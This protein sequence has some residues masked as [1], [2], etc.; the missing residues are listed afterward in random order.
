[1]FMQWLRDYLVF[2]RTEI[3]GVMVV[4]EQVLAGVRASD[5]AYGGEPDRAQSIAASGRQRMQILMCCNAGYIQHLAVVVLS[6]AAQPTKYGIDVLVVMGAP[7]VNDIMALQNSLLR[8]PHVTLRTLTFSPDPDLH[9]PIRMHYSRDMY[10]R[11]WVAEFFDASVRRVLYLDS[12]MVVTGSLDELWETDLRGNTIGAVTIPGSTRCGLLDIPE[13]YGYFN[14]GVLLID[15]AQW[16]ERNIFPKLLNFIEHNSEKLPDGD[17]DVLNA[18]MH[19]DRFALDFVWNVISPFYFDYHDLRLP[20]GEVPRIQAGARIVHFNGASK[21]WSYF[22]RHP[23]RA[24][25]YKYLELT[26][27]R[28]FTPPDRTVMNRL[29]R[30]ASSLVPGRVR[31]FLARKS[32]AS[33][34][35]AVLF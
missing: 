20:K 33:A 7:E 23:R 29:R 9:L 24:D 35:E 19:A 15:L 31:R 13:A 12:D 2:F 10:T 30:A 25:Y 14:S 6:L 16:R 34:K 5:A 11:L 21:P 28:D 26:P 18:M 27:W 4:P 1:M 3:G 32:K 22:S 8:F 17:Q